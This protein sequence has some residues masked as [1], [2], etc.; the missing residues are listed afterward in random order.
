MSPL[1]TSATLPAVWQ[2]SAG[3]VSRSYADDVLLKSGVVLIGPGDAGQ[4][5][6][7]RDDSEF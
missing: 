7:E 3:P 4:W 1:G 2:I 6:P 5:T